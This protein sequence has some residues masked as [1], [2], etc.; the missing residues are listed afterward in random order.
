MSLSDLDLPISVTTGYTNPVESLFVPLLQNCREFDVAV[1]YFTSGWLRDTAPGIAE[2]AIN[3]GKSRWVVSPELQPEDVTSML[4]GVSQEEVQEY[5][6]RK[7][8]DVIAQLQEDTRKELCALIACKIIQFRIAIPRSGPGL[9]HAKIAIARDGTG[10]KIGC[11]G[12]YNFTSAASSNWE[13]IDVFKSWAGDGAV[14]VSLLEER[15]EALW[16]ASDPK[17]QV[18]TPSIA[19]LEK[20]RDS[21]NSAVDRYKHL[22]ESNELEENTEITLRPYQQTA[23]D[24]WGSNNG[25]GTYVMATGSGKTITALA[26]INRLVER[27]VAT[28]GGMLTVVI[29]VPLKHLLDQW[30]DEAREFGF[31]PIRCYESS[32]LWVSRL[33]A[34]L[35][36]VSAV[37]NG[38]IIALVTNATLTSEHFQKFMSNVTGNFLFVA[39]EAHNLGAKTYL[40]ALP[41]NANFRLALSATPQRYNDDFGTE[42][43]FEY[44]GEPVIEFT[45]KD[46]IDSG[47]L[48][49]YIYIPTICELTESEYE[50][51]LEL[52]QLIKE[53]SKKS[54]EAGERTREHDRLLGK[55]ADLISGVESKLTTLENQ[56]REQRAKGEVTHTLVYCGSR[57]GADDRRHIERTIELIGTKFDIKARK[58]TAAESMD[59]RRQ[60]LKLFGSGELGLIAAIKC[61]DEGVDVPATKVAYIL[62]STTN[63]REY[64]QRR[65]RVLRKYPGKE[66]AVIYDYLVTPPDE[67]ATES[68][69]VERELERAWEFAELAVNRG[70]CAPLLDSVAREYRIS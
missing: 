2:F 36:A 13:H 57:K 70:D 24:K 35:G 30:Y 59:D 56:L 60:M 17:Y 44:F 6:E 34:Q 65:G 25:R 27:I 15:F 28:Q 5:A 47:F 38:A 18:F 50:E 22:T 20:I 52:S 58:F 29:V 54:K 62:A 42:A 10:D 55:R 21:A 53:E 23:I 41:K 40:D 48:C 8:S 19:F 26:T 16:T 33:S 12:S 49:N 67:A 1:G 37:G 7:L 14:R 4:D 63:P 3:G 69:L 31:S 51:Y 61:L 45:L 66:L 68:D 39:D 64:I 9:F 11:S 46:A 32:V 43:L